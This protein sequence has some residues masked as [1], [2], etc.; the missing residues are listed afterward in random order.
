MFK[1]YTLQ[2]IKQLDINPQIVGVELEPIVR[3]EAA[4]FV[5]IHFQDCP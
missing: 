3:K 1:A 5:N 4:V 2:G